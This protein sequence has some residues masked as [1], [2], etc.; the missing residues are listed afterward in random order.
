MIHRSSSIIRRKIL[1]LPM[2]LCLTAAQAW[3]HAR[4]DH[5]EPA[6]DATVTTSPNEVRLTFSESVEAKFCRVQVL[7]AAGQEVDTKDVHADPKK[8]E[9]AGRVSARRA[10]CRNVQGGLARRRGGHARHQG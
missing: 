1:L 5:S 4:L 8:R 6:A 9:R 7:D 3:A 10:R 2:V